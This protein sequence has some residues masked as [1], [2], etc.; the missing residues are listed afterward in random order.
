MAIFADSNEKQ[1]I[2]SNG[3]KWKKKAT[4]PICTLGQTATRYYNKIWKTNYFS[5]QK[6]FSREKYNQSKSSRFDWKIIK[7]E[8]SVGLIVRR[9]NMLGQEYFLFK[10]EV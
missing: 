6:I 1:F 9:C 5:N 2:I 4:T 8:K 10:G 3:A 7:S